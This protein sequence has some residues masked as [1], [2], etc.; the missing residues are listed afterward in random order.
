[1]NDYLFYLRVLDDSGVD[2]LIASVIILCTWS[3]LDS[4][5]GGNDA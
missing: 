2:S 3:M 1:M 5:R 4:D